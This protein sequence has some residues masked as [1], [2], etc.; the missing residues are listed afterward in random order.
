MLVSAIAMALCAPYAAAQSADPEETVVPVALDTGW[1]ANAEKTRGIRL[2]FDTAVLGAAGSEPTVLRITSLYDGASQT[3][4]ARHLRQWQDTSAY[5]NGHRLRLEIIAD[6]DAAPSRVALSQ[7]V[8][9]TGPAPQPRTICG[10]EDD[11]VLSLDPR[12][13]RI[14][15]TICTAW[16][17][18]D[19]AHCFLTAGHC[20][21]SGTQVVEFNVPLSD[22]N[23]NVQHPGPED[24]YPVDP[25]S[26]QSSGNGG[27]GNDWAYFGCFPNT[28][29]GLSPAEVQGTWFQRASTP[30]P[31]QGQSIQITGY[32]STSSPVPNEW[33][34][35]QKT[36]TGPYAANAG[37]Y[38]QYSTDTTGGNSGSPVVD[39]ST[40]LAIGIHTHGGCSS[41]GGANHGTAIDNPNLLAAIATPLGICAPVACI[42]DITGPLSGVPDGSVDALDILRLIS[43]WGSPCGFPCDADI[44]GPIPEI[45]DNN[46]DALDL[47][48]MISQWGSPAACN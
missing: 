46:V 4:N 25:T 14:A 45:P 32:G 19:A 5:F 30:P 6:A 39:W 36:H 7:A 33:Y 24:Q 3:L 34:K 44:T 9:G 40:G 47:L 15:P 12:M 8:V 13:G 31:V 38:L 11:R 2:Y 41:G 21:G 35:V 26:I 23:G 20:T 37:S 29:T 28:E 43:Q 10:P 27:V 22:A 16:L 1:V 17:I 48:I 42:S 18:D